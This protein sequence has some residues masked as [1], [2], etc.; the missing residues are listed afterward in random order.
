M[1]L[2][3]RSVMMCVGSTA[4]STVKHCNNLTASML[5]VYSSLED[6]MHNIN[7]ER[8]TFR[9]VDGI[10]VGLGKADGAAATYAKYAVH[11]A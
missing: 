5:I 10:Q 1:E 11:Q 3:Q 7:Q 6:T 4:E 9:V 8:F 2:P